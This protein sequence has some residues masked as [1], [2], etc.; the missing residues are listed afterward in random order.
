MLCVL[1]RQLLRSL[2]TVLLVFDG[3]IIFAWRVFT[4][5]QQLYLGYLSVF[6]FFYGAPII[7]FEENA[8]RSWIKRLSILNIKFIAYIYKVMAWLRGFL[9]S[10]QYFVS[11]NPDNINRFYKYIYPCYRRICICIADSYVL[12]TSIC[13]ADLATKVIYLIILIGIWRID[14]C[15]AALWLATR[16]LLFND[17]I[18]K[19]LR[20]ALRPLATAL[21]FLSDGIIGIRQLYYFCL[22]GIY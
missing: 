5:Y 10:A 18:N 21:T 20:Y 22:A 14:L 16:L 1:Q 2:A 12:M 6:P 13:I 3:F 4:K 15:Y 17:T 7:A 19:Y 11:L 9:Y 8:C